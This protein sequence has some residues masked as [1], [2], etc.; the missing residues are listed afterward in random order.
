MGKTIYWEKKK[1]TLKQTLGHI[2]N[3][4]SVF[5][6]WNSLIN[7]QSPSTLDGLF[8]HQYFSLQDTTLNS[9]YWGPTTP[10]QEGVGVM[11]EDLARNCQVGKRSAL[12][13]RIWAGRSMVIKCDIV[14]I[15]DLG[16]QFILLIQVTWLDTNYLQKEGKKEKR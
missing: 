4:L 5:Y 11:N 10:P 6:S 16:L 7:K 14:Y 12:L 15:S 3:S 2:S 1:A 9:L 8:V 13:L